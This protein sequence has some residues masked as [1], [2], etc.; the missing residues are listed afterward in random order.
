[1]ATCPTCRT[2][3]SDDTQVC[4]T[5]GETLLPDAA[6]T[7]A[8]A[9]LTSGTT[10]G[11]YQ[12]EKKLGEGGFGAVYKAVHPLIGK[13]AAIKVLN[14]QF[15]S[16]P[17]M[18]SRFIAEA[19][20][21]NQIRHRNI[22]DIFSFGALPDGRQ[23]FVMELLDGMP[24]DAYLRKKGRL[25]PDEVIAILRPLA[26]ALDAAHAA[27]IAHR[28]LK[29]ENIFLG[30][31]Q[32]GSIFP[33]LLDFGIAKLM[34]TGS[35][36]SKTK[37]GTPMGTPYYMSPE[38]CRGTEVDHRTD[39]YAFGVMCHQLL[40]GKLPFDSD[41]V[42]D[43]LMKQMTAPPP[44]LSS[45]SALPSALDAPIKKM[46]EKAPADRYP[47]VGAALEALVQ[48]CAS[49]GVSTSGGVALPSGPQL[50][51]SGP[52]ASLKNATPAALES[53]GGAKTIAADAAASQT[54]QGSESDVPRQPK[55]TS[56]FVGLGLGAVALVAAGVVGAKMMSEPT[57]P[58]PG[59]L[60]M[61][62]DSAP[63]PPPVTQVPSQAPPVATSAAA[64]REEV[65]ITIKSHPEHAAVFLGKE[66]VGT[67]P[68][69]ILL[70]KGNDKVKLTVKADGFAPKDVEVEPTE[71][72]TLEVNLTKLGRSTGGQQKTHG[73]LE[74]PTF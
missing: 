52:P 65:K 43:L 72:S 64:A 25:S 36:A 54:F 55:R 16:N 51:Q 10:V 35:G 44:A 41:N 62:A 5:D 50:Y 11:E 46:L 30:F 7:S 73:D 2:R 58:H 42:M 20:S 56:L 39:V 61:S 31:E 71:N 12:V 40:S 13:Q 68:G 48:A 47:S 17:Q 38:Q 29:P 21:V 69:P 15:S 6:F 63:A 74:A 3:Y 22:I 8:D 32:D 59:K 19:K 33:K 9:D 18:V 45:V 28:D 4:A 24:L 57:S 26:R 37:T 27:G 34:G 49:A 1:V 23:Y 53:F 70:K 14:R 67:A 66:A 60:V